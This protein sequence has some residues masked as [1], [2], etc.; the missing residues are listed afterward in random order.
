VEINGYFYLG[1]ILRPIGIQGK[2]LIYLD[3]DDPQQYS[4]LDA[5][6]VYV[7]GNLVPF[8][9]REIQMLP[10]KQAHVTFQDVDNLDQIEMLT[11]AALYLPVEA[12]PELGENEF[13]YHEI[14]GY[15][16]VDHKYGELGTV[17][18]VL[19]YPMQALLQLRRG[20]KEILIP[21]ADEIITAVDKK[22]RSIH[23]KAPE[24]LIE[25]YLE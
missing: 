1:K 2:L 18:K 25:M 8:L 24:G 16:V 17:E 7:G 20:E 22:N 14:N 10:G 13:Y 5:V 21:V 3:V 6:F 19:D 4:G 23:I 12:L 11:G 9:I 15:M